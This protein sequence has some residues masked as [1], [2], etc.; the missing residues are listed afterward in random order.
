MIYSTHTKFVRQ[1]VN[2]KRSKNH[3]ALIRVFWSLTQRNKSTGCQLRKYV[4]SSTDENQIQAHIENS[5]FINSMIEIYKVM[6]FVNEH[7]VWISAFCTRIY[8]LFYLTYHNELTKSLQNNHLDIKN[9]FGFEN[10]CLSDSFCICTWE[11]WMLYWSINVCVF[12][13]KWIKLYRRILS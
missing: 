6:S 9:D 2:W 12:K 8:A 11:N 5:D 1:I 7:T 4:T 3:Q 13:L 10:S